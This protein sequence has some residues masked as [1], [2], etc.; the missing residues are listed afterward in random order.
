MYMTVHIILC[1]LYFFV[2]IWLPSGKCIEA[3]FK[4]GQLC[5]K[6]KPI[7]K[8]GGAKAPFEAPSEINPGIVDK[9]SQGGAC[10]WY[11]LSEHASIFLHKTIW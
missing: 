11:T 6:E 8:E 4:R 5:I 1:M 10:P 2:A 7:A 3:K 9:G